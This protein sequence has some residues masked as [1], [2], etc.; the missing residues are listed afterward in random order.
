MEYITSKIKKNV[1]SDNVSF[2]LW[3]DKD[4][5]NSLLCIYN[6]VFRFTHVSGSLK[7]YLLGE[8]KM[9]Y[10]DIDNE[11]IKTAYRRARKGE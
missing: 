9:I 11:I 10:P 5:E 3:D 6:Q 7:E 1:K 8:I 2:L 4:L